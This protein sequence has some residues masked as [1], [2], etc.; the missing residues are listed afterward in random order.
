MVFAA[1]EITLQLH[2]PTQ[3]PL[4]HCLQFYW[5][6]CALQ[7]KIP[8]PH[9]G[10]Y[11]SAQ[12]PSCVLWQ[13]QEFLTLCTSCRSCS[14]ITSHLWCLIKREPKWYFGSWSWPVLAAKRRIS[15]SSEWFSHLWAARAKLAA[16]VLD[17]VRGSVCATHFVHDFIIWTP[18][19]KVG[20]QVKL[21]L[22]V[23]PN[24]LFLESQL[25]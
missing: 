17:A 5:V 14:V 11:F 20:V 18:L 13:L 8:C 24:C 22:A 12:F 15:Q 2:G 23:F 10:F 6:E 4:P 25:K 16:S 9:C 21:L 1:S 19:M 7:C 3:I